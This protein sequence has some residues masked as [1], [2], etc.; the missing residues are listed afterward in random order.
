LP[1]SWFVSP[2][3]MTGKDASGDAPVIPAV[4]HVYSLKPK[5]FTQR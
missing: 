4:M 2:W 1:C 3:P 5:Y